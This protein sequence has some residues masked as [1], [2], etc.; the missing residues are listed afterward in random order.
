MY[1]SFS[2]VDMWSC[3]VARPWYKLF[4]FQQ[5][6][7]LYLPANTQNESRTTSASTQTSINSNITLCKYLQRQT[8]TLKISKEKLTCCWEKTKRNKLY[9][10]IGFELQSR[11]TNFRPKYGIYYRSRME[12]KCNNCQFLLARNFLLV[13]RA[14]LTLFGSRLL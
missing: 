6:G 13:T 3:P 7:K 10:F 14:L 5:F 2:L 12:K 9:D 8:T 4:P 11:S 1:D